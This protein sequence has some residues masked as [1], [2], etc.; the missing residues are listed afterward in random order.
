MSYIGKTHPPQY[1]SISYF[2]FQ[3]LVPKCCTCWDVWKLFLPTTKLREEIFSYQLASWH[4]LPGV[5]K[6]QQSPWLDTPCWF[7]KNQMQKLD[8]N[9]TPQAKWAA[10]GDCCHGWTNGWSSDVLSLL[11]LHPCGPCEFN[12]D[13]L[14]MICF[15]VPNLLF[16]GW[17]SGSISNFKG[18]KTF[19]EFP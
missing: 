2:P 5:L 1:S 13:N 8:V 18:C 6:Y 4:Q 14:K 7:S 11:I 16:R 19:S 9:K 10:M 15:Q 12:I 17:S 3:L